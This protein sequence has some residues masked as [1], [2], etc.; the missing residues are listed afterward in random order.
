MIINTVCI[1]IIENEPNL[2]I[3]RVGCPVDKLRG[4]SYLDF[5]HFAEQIPVSAMLDDALHLNS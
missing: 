5:G 2:L 4:R 1:T 3:S